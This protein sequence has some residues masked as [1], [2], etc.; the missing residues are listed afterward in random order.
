M[1]YGTPHADLNI[2]IGWLLV[3]CGLQERESHSLW[4]PATRGRIS[5][6]VGAQAGQREFEDD[7]DKWSDFLYI[8]TGL[9]STFLHAFHRAY[10]LS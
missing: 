6:L 3:S 7:K 1:I 9:E 5:G 4:M 8:V 2:W 10:I